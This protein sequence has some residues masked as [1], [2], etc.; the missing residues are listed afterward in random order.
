MSQRRGRQ[1]AA[2]GTS[3]D[4][5]DRLVAGLTLRSQHL[6]LPCP[7]GSPPAQRTQSRSTY[8]L[9]RVWLWL[10]WI[11]WICAVVTPESSPPA[12]TR[13]SV[14]GHANGQQNCPIGQ[15]PSSQGSKAP[16][17]SDDEHAWTLPR[18]PTTRPSCGSSGGSPSRVDPIQASSKAELG[19]EPSPGPPTSSQR[20]SLVSPIV[21]LRA[22]RGRGGPPHRRRGHRRAAATSGSSPAT[23][24][25]RS[26]EPDVASLRARVNCCALP[27]SAAARHVLSAD[28]RLA[29]TP[30][31]RLTAHR[32]PAA[33]V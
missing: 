32:Q 7:F 12:R 2:G 1:A 25:P 28:P 19:A 23:T 33:R 18:L 11:G 22:W 14:A 3:V 5:P 26:R 9:E 21:P 13:A 27:G 24:P 8:E 6:P 31:A 15:A 30:S 17:R 20:C 29:L 16:R 10:S 4:R